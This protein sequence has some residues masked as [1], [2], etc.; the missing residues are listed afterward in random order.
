MKFVVDTAK[1]LLGKK[2]VIGQEAVRIIITVIVMEIQ[3]MH[4][5]IK[6]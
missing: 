5:I 1:V 6:T 3:F 2:K 4:L